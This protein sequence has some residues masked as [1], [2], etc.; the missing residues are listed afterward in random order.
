MVCGFCP[1]SGSGSAAE[2]S[3]NR[4]DVFKRHLAS[5]HGA[6]QNPPNGR[7]KSP[8]TSNGKGSASAQDVSGRC[9]TCLAMFKNAQELYEH[10]DDCVLHVVQQEE[11]SEAI[12]ER[13]MQS[14]ANDD[15]VRETLERHTLPSEIEL[16]NEFGTASDAEDD[17]D[18]S[19]DYIENT[20]NQS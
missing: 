1:G 20:G 10:L 2:K 8:V 12:N 3:F 17:D 14:V 9:S 11:P 4:A 16:G 13:I 5:V 18:D 6:E 7:K 19:N 15:N